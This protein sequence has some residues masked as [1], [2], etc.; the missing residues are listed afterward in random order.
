[1]NYGHES[2]TRTFMAE[3][4]F[5]L[6]EEIALVTLNKPHVM[7]V[8]GKKLVEELREIISHMEQDDS[9]RVMILTGA[10]EKAFCAGADLKERRE[11]TDVE[12]QRFRNYSL[13]PMFRELEGM[14][15]P[16]IAAVNGFAFGGGL[17]LALTCDIILASE[18]A[19]FAQQEVKWGIIPAAGACQKLP[20]LIGML[21]AKEL[22]LTGRIIDAK[23]AERIGLVN[24]VYKKEELME[25]TG[26]MAK[27]ICEN[28]PMA[29]KTAKRCMD[30]GMDITPQLAFDFETSN[31]CYTYKD[32]EEGI[33]A[34][35]EG[36]KPS[37]P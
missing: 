13:F 7:N 31:L 35:I 37:Y 26:E 27:Q 28:S 1:M 18:D 20:R 6:K 15:K 17:E 12:V 30:V 19:R 29:V 32:R 8:L 16:S 25:K 3:V 9:I 2:R 4:L 5:E 23:E 22:I 14:R 33:K 34:F 11:M 24:H 36:K 21:K 10:G